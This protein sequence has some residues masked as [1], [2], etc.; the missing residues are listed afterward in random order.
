MRNKRVTILGVSQPA[1]ACNKPSEV[2]VSRKKSLKIARHIPQLNPRLT[3]Y[4]SSVE[5]AKIS[6]SERHALF[7]PPGYV[8]AHCADHHRHRPQPRGF[9]ASIANL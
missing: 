5:Q 8:A 6:V 2:F 1:S 9:H 4:E 7:Q 3:I